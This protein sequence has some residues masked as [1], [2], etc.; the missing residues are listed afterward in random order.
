MPKAIHYATND[1]Y[2]MFHLPMSTIAVQQRF[3]LQEVLNNNVGNISSNVG[4]FYWSNNKYS[5]KRTYLELSGNPTPGAPKPFKWI[6]KSSC[7]T[8]QKFFF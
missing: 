1:I 7:L 8:K 4:K 5:T 6:C 3:D 2:E